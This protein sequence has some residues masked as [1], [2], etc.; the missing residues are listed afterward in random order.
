MEAHNDN[1]NKPYIFRPEFG[2]EADIARLIGQYKAYTQVVQLFSPH[3][4]LKGA[5]TVLDIGCG[6]GC[7]AI[8]V[9][10][11]YP[12]MSV[13]GLDVD[14]SAVR[15]AMTHA[16]SSGHENVTFEVYD[17]TTGLPFSDASVDYIHLS[18]A[19]SFLLKS[20]WPPLLAECYRVLKPGG[21]LRSV[22]WLCT[23]TSSFAIF[24]MTQLFNLALAQDGRR[25]VELAPHLESLLKNAGLVPAPLIV[26]V[27]NFSENTPAHRTIA[28]SYYVSAL[29]S[30]PFIFKR[31]VASEEEIKRL[32]DETQ[33]DMMLPGFYGLTTLTDIA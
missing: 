9:A 13:I 22:E 8:D 18:L 29:L 33:R 20:Q 28:E 16:T 3:C 4:Q 17:V 23:Q 30:S 15:Y 6:P 32:I 26:H 24:R 2:N 21:W 10:F 1:S 14:E 12:A 19:N 5:E 25:Y 31:G 11:Q 7:W 27:V